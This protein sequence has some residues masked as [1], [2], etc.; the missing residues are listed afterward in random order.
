MDGS[1]DHQFAGFDAGADL[2]I[3]S[4]GKAMLLEL[5]RAFDFAVNGEVLTAEDLAL[6]NH[7]LT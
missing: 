6:H 5:H 2:S 3:G 4:D 7:G 1:Q